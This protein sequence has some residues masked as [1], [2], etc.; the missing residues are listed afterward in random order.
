MRK[1]DN[2]HVLIVKKSEGLNV[3]EPCL[4]DQVC[5]GTALPLHFTYTLEFSALWS[6]L[7]GNPDLIF[8]HI[9]RMADGLLHF[10]LHHTSVSFI[11]CLK[12]Y[13]NNLGCVFLAKEVT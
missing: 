12:E 11:N 8:P 10:V 3:L 5:N 9:V 4:P 1:A 7:L 6:G 13:E 2:L